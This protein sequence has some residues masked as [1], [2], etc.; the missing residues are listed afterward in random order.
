MI[1]RYII[2]KP[3]DRKCSQIAILQT[4]CIPTDLKPFLYSLELTLCK[5]RTRTAS[6]PEPVLYLSSP[7]LWVIVE[8]INV[9]VDWQRC[10][11]TNTKGPYPNE[12]LSERPDVLSHWYHDIIILHRTCIKSDLMLQRTAVITDLMLHTYYVGLIS[13]QTFYYICLWLYHILII[14]YN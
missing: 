4:C 10:R 13:C 7:I 6:N 11:L 5:V 9:R 12:T 1:E 3:L 2:L 14:T 8:Q